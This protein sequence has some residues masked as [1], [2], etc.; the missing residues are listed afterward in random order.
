MKSNARKAGCGPLGW[1]QRLSQNG[2]GLIE[3]MVAMVIGLISTL[4]IFQT[5]SASEER[6]RTTTSGS[7]GLQ[8]S[9]FALGYIER[10]VMNS[11]YGVVG[12]SDPAYRSMTRLIDLGAGSYT[13]SSTQAPEPEL[14]IGCNANVG[15]AVRRIAPLVA[16]TG[17]A[18]VATDTITILAANNLAVPLPVATVPVAVAGGVGS[19]VISSTY[20]FNVGDWL[21][22]YDQNTSP[23]ANP[24]TAR[25]TPCTLTQVGAL[26]NAP[27]IK[28]ATVN[29]TTPLAAPLSVGA[30]INLGSNPTYT[31]LTVDGNARLVAIN[32]LTPGV[33]PQ[34][35]A[36]NVL[37]MKLQLGV[38]VGADDVIDAWI[39]PPAAEANW[40][41]P[42]N[43][44]PILAISALPVPV[45]PPAL[46]QVKSLRI[47]LLVQSPQFERLDAAGQ[48]STTGPGPFEILPP[49]AG[50]NAQRL[51]AMPGSGVYNLAGNQRCFRY[52][53]VNSIVP[54]RNILLGEM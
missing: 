5:F 27:I 46:H 52:N 8:S 17:G 18:G 12:I 54:L 53:T 6:K 10:M 38:D 30:V 15:G 2:F 28:D 26:P 40:T 29:L 47:G 45:A 21:L 42:V 25:P 13:L 35:I 24:G 11:G 33:P 1:S 36:E 23:A 4:A 14:H 39:N 31:Q 50:A 20:G 19:V 3:L 9:L 51:P 41:N 34:V 32:L 44:L 49:I 22:L 48:C 43:P 7:E 16:T 37:S